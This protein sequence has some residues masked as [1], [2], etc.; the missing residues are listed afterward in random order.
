MNAK[1][2]WT[3]FGP[4]VEKPRPSLTVAA[5]A[6]LF[7]A[8]TFTATEEQYPI[9]MCAL[10]W[11]SAAWLTWFAVKKSALIGLLTI[12]VSLL[13]L[14]PVTGGAWFSDMG[15]EYLLSHSALALVWAACAYTFMATEKR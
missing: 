12:P 5:V 2:N 11:I 8:Q 10:A 13:W 6:I 9:Y 15:I 1:A 7:A 14:N 4:K 3:L